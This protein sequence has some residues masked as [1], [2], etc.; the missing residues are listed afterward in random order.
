MPIA[1]FSAGGPPRL[2]K[3]F[4][5]FL[6]DLTVAAPAAPS[7][8]VAFLRMG[9]EALAEFRR[10]GGDSPGR[11][12]LADVQLHA[13]SPNPEKYL[14]I[15]MNYADHSAEAKALGVDVPQ[16]QTWFNKQV[17]CIH[18][19][20]DDVISPRVSEKMDYEGELA[21]VIG[22]AC[23]YASPEQAPAFVGG[24]MIANDVSARDWQARTGTVTL[25]KSFDTHGPTGP[26]LT[27]P[28][29]IGDP[30]RLEIRTFVNGE[31]RQ[32]ASTAD[33]IHSIWDQISY[34]SQVMTLKPG[35]ILATGT[36]AGVGVARKPPVFLRP[37]DVVRVEISGLGRIENRVIA[38][39]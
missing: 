35:D 14:A 7:D 2:G 19:P 21:V 34:L 37:G 9:E 20:F 3:V 23:R 32:H 30:H 8:L 16:W 33:L 29:E 31:V 12:A 17:S 39:A 22:K 18:G 24:Y 6:I 1:R 10:V 15:G 36:P 25:G 26:W 11:H 13:P 5:D 28:E 38:E 4:E 27:L